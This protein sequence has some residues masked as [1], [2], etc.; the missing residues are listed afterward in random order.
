MLT[1]AQRADMADRL[2]RVAVE[3]C[4]AALLR[5]KREMQEALS[6]A[7]GARERAVALTSIGGRDGPP[8]ECIGG[9]NSPAWEVLEMYEDLLAQVLRTRKAESRQARRRTNKKPPTAPTVEG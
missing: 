9:A 2:L 5:A 6:L 7:W 4:A 8:Q 3:I 1:E